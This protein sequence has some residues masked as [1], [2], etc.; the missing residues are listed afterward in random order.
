MT[1][2][3]SRF[4]TVVFS[5]FLGGLLLWHIALPDKDRS[6]TENRTLAQIPAYSWASLKDGSFT[7]AV[8]DY[9]TDQFPLR[10]KWTGMKARAEQLIGKSRFNGIYLCGD[11]LIA[12]IETP[13]EAQVKKNLTYVER[14]SGMTDVPVQMGV[15]PSAAHV[16]KDKLPKGAVSWDQTALLAESDIDFAGALA[17]HKDEAIYYRTD[18]HWT[19]LG[20]FY[21]ANALLE[22]WGMEPL[23][24][25]EFKPE[26]A[27]DVFCGTLYSTSGIHFLKPD[28]MEYWVEED[29]K[30]LTSW[31]NGKEVSAPLYDRSYLEAKD[32]YSSFLGGNQPLAV[33]RNEALEGGEKLLVIRDSYSD[34]LA[35][36]LAERFAEV[37]L[38]D[39]RYY[40]L[41]V[42]KYVEENDI[43]RVCVLYS[44]Q[45]FITEKNV[46][47]LTQ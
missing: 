1:K 45:N 14:F 32:K 21:G 35:P 5:L 16:W 13:D 36:F 12:E 33:I 44:A 19:T 2:A 25:D 3:Y 22:S 15:I 10:D 38:I 39:L 29:G 42:A 8:E 28:T 43:D 47:M 23:T 37:H 26:T 24:R 6:E 11:T 27:S 9:F 46:F 18:H 34:A 4:I 31:K 40:R 17:A 41:S 7:K 30:S 20:A